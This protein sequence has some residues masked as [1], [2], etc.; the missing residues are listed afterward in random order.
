MELLTGFQACIIG[1]AFLFHAVSF[2]S[3]S[4]GTGSLEDAL[5]GGPFHV[6][7]PWA[8]T[9]SLLAPFPSCSL[10]SASIRPLQTAV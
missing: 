6:E 3:K 9:F 5:N 7:Q 1:Y 10:V 4:H 2:S 8:S